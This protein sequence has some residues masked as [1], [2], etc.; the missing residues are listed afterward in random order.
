M[1]KCEALK[2]IVLAH[3][4]RT[5]FESVTINVSQ[6]RFAFLLLERHLYAVLNWN[7]Q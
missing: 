5:M 4:M 6:T 7:M 1:S 3:N 2:C